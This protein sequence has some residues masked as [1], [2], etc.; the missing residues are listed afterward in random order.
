MKSECAPGISKELGGLFLFSFSS[1]REKNF[2]SKYTHRQRRTPL[3]LTPGKLQRQGFV[4]TRG[5]DVVSQN[6]CLLG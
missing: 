4:D 6:C 1:I 3:R 5:C 2:P